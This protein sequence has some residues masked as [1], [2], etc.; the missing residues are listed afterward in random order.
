MKDFLEELGLFAIQAA[1]AVV[2]AAGLV[3]LAHFPCD[4]DHPML[5]A[6][7]AKARAFYA[8]AYDPAKSNA[9]SPE[10][11]RYAKVALDAAKFWH[12]TDQVRDFARNFK[13]QDKKVLDIGSGQGYLQDVVPDYTGLDISPTVVRYY[14]KNFI[15]GSATSMPFK[16]D[17]FDGAWSIWVLEHVPNPEA[18][19][20]EVRR[21]VKDNG[22]LF[23]APAWDCVP[24]AADG[25]D[26]RPFSDFGSRGKLIKATVPAR[27]AMDRFSTPLVRYSLYISWRLWGEPTTFRYHRLTPNLQTYWEPDSDA[28]NVLDF[29]E[30]S[31]WFRSRGDECLNCGT[32][33]A[34][35][36]QATLC[37][38]CARVPF[39]PLIIRV[40][41]TAQASLSK[42]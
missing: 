2:A 24:W 3:I 9:I 6:D 19:L 28:V 13:L 18:A 32:S 34:R 7:A 37:E 17:S 8:T 27:L 30:M 23:L 35:I 26:I 20:N 33:G 31:L 5:A 39:T 1:A 41:K 14:H 22:V 36:M 10:D 25:Y 15:L 11:A 38:G 29:Y 4:T 40:H 21:V 16:D 42:R 12:V